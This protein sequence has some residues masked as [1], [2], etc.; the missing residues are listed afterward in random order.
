MGGITLQRTG[1][2]HVVVRVLRDGGDVIG[3]GGH[4]RPRCEFAEIG[5]R[6]LGCQASDLADL[7]ALEQVVRFGYELRGEDEDKRAASPLVKQLWQQTD[8]QASGPPLSAWPA[9]PAG[10]YFLAYA[11]APVKSRATHASLPT[12]HASCPGGI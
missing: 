5:I 4:L 10:P 11:A 7:R 3:A 9:G 1:Q 8:R 12:I 6:F 2:D